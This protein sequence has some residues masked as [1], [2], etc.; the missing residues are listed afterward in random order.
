MGCSTMILADAP[1][2]AASSFALAEALLRTPPPEVSESGAEDVFRRYYGRE[3]RA[4]L[5][6]G[7]RDRNFLITEADGRSSV[8][9]FFNPIDDTATRALQNGALR[10]VHAHTVDCPVP[11]IQAAFDGCDEVIVG[12]RGTEMAAVMISLLPGVNPVATDIGPALRADIGR[13]IGLLSHALSGYSPANAGRAILWD[14][15]H[16]AELA[17]LATLIADAPRRTA[18]ERFLA[19]FAETVR[20]ATSNLPHQVIHN[21][22]SLSNIL[23][24]PIRR[25]RVT[26]VIDFGDIVAAPRINEFAVAASYFIAPGTDPMVP[27]AEILAGAAANL[28]LH[29]E[30]VALVPDLIRARLATRILVSGWRAQLFPENSA[31]ILRSNL[32]AW[33]LWES[34]AEEQAEVQSHRLLTL[35]DKVLP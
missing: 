2:F 17:P 31:Y 16:V 21:D 20:P 12:L 26:G 15:M 13:V 5:L 35:L 10:H 23:I 28:I 18:I 8:L 9:K 27:V 14:M 19:R 22:L 6:S 33:A 11:E 30:E 25:D 3:A 7:E 32:A 4:R 1:I 24:D 34:L 29:R